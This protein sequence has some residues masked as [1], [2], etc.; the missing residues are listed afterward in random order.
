[1]TTRAA[2]IDLDEAV[3]QRGWGPRLVISEEATNGMKFFLE[4]CHKFDNS[5]IRSTATEIS[6]VSIIAPP[7]KL[8]YEAKLRC[9]SYSY[10][11]KR[12]SGPATLPALPLALIL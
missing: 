2:Y 4:N 10:K 11:W 12:R 8:F 1:M 7:P 5:P 6:V 3:R 9:K